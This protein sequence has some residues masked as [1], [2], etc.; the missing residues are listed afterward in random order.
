MTDSST[1]SRGEA[2]AILAIWVLFAVWVIG[3][4]ACRAYPEEPAEIRLALGFPSWVVWGVALPWL[5]AT[6]LTI[7]FS[8]VVMKDEPVESSDVDGA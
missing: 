7:V 6:L 3:Y 8:L 4:A 5:V 1:R 2:I